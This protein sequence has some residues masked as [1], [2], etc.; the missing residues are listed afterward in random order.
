M[1][2]SLKNDANFRWLLSGGILSML[3]DQFTL[4]ALPW[5]VLK[6]TG[7][8]LSLGLVL[9]LLGAPRAIFIL[10]GGALVDRYSPKR[11]LMLSKHASALLLV[12]VAS[13]WAPFPFASEARKICSTQGET[14]SPVPR[15]CTV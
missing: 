11:V 7:D 9:A 13:N 2:P 8:P 5:L 4:I 10:V 1:A 14:A 12:K 3:G 15:F 6:L